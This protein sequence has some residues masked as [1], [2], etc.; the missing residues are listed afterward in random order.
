MASLLNVYWHQDIVGTLH[1][2]E[3]RH[4]VFQY[5]PDWLK[6]ENPVP[7]SLSLPLQAEAYNN[8]R[9]RPFF[10]NLLPESDLR[11][12][13]ARKLGL[14]EQND[15]ALLEAVGGECAGAVSLLPEGQV[16]GSDGRYRPLD[17]KQLNILITELPTRPMLAGEEGIRLSLAGAQ[18][19]LPVYFDGNQISLP[20]GNATSSHIVKPPIKHY[21]QTVENETFCMLL[22]TRMDLPVPDITI[23]HKAEPLYLITRYDRQQS[24]QQDHI[25]RLHQEDFCQ[26]LGI[27]PDMKY[28]KEGGPSLKACFELLRHNSIQPVADVRNLLHW[29]VF[30]YL[31]G[32]ADAHAKNIALLFT[33]SGPA[34]APFYDL[35]C[36]VV[37][38]EL[39]DRIAMKIGGED[40]PDW[41][42]TRRWQQFAE[43]IDV[44]Y[45]LVKQTLESMSERIITE[46]KMVQKEFNK[47]Y[48]ECA[49]I[50]N[51]I[52]I[53]KTRS[54]FVM[55]AQA[56]I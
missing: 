17:D 29:V 2:D 44:G 54:A 51:I 36:T 41:I 8:D 20:M 24:N 26:A 37:Y 21:P 40:R 48:G 47:Q 43:E 30:N 19:K 4:F 49:L 27:A 38:A 23:L 42:I 13:I 1:L 6:R 22:A 56:G 15:F 5:A 55:S 14:S 7:L 3:G 28:E 50:E 31:I 16:P 39:T 25:T 32:N 33:R 9:A 11:R 35:M 52:N 18:N 10:A 53:I 12:S 46:A 45:K 34:L